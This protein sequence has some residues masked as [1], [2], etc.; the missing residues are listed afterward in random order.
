MRPDETREILLV[1]TVPE[2]SD[3]YAIDHFTKA[4]AR[5]LPMKWSLR[6]L[7]PGERF[8]DDE[9]ALLIRT[10]R[11]IRFKGFGPQEMREADAAAL[12]RMAGLED[13]DA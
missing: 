5:E 4:M 13:A 6:P 1:L 8:T 7:P 10:A 11:D 9:K 12:R 2:E 3:D